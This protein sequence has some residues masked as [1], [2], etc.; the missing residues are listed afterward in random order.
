MKTAITSILLSL[1]LFYLCSSAEE[2]KKEAKENT[3]KKDQPA[4]EIKL[5]SKHET[6]AVFKGT[7]TRECKGLTLLCPNECGH[8]GEFA[9][10]EITTYNTYE[11]PGEYGDPKQAT[12]IIQLTSTI[13]RPMDN[14]KAIELVKTLKIGDKVTLNWNHNYV[15][16]T[17]PDGG[18]TK[19]PERVIVKLEKLNPDANEPLKEKK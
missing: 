4:R 2:P 17:Y 14:K 10:F 18:S 1:S 8:S 5:L 19:S 11:K 6:T 12:Y 13:K 7:E 3:E 9:T 16:T 15:T